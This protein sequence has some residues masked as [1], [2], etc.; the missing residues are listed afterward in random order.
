MPSIQ[1]VSL[2]VDG[3][4]HAITLNG[5]TLHVAMRIS[6]TVDIFV[7]HNDEKKRKKGEEETDTFVPFKYQFR[8]FK[9]DEP[10]PSEA[11]H[12]IGT[13]APLNGSPAIHVF[14][15]N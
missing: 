7:I 9:T 12:Y 14:R 2:P 5:R 13:A 1:R 10:L 11:V 3:R 15:R 6:G 4:W 8:A